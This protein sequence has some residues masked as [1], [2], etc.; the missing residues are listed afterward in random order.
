MPIFI[1][2][3]GL[4]VSLM[5]DPRTLSWVNFMQVKKVK[6]DFMVESGDS[7][8]MGVLKINNKYYKIDVKVIEKKYYASFL[9]Y[10]GSGKYF[11][12][13]I[14]GVA[15]DKGYKLN[16]YGIEDLKTGKL[17]T[18]LGPLP[19]CKIKELW[20]V[21]SERNFQEENNYEGFLRDSNFLFQEIIFQLKDLCYV[22]FY[23]QYPGNRN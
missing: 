13:Y 8:F 16:Q 22:L 6:V 4:L 7:G 19:R 21:F 14:R 2:D 17:K 3:F 5:G 11:S 1:H 9:L 10:F 20:K 12:K 23:L 18:T 15:K